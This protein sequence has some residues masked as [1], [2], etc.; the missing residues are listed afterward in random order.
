MTGINTGET[1]CR[2]EKAAYAAMERMEQIGT[3]SDKADTKAAVLASMAA[4]G[5]MCR[6]TGICL[7]NN[8]T[9]ASSLIG[10]Y[11]SI[12]EQASKIGVNCEVVID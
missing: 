11:T 2:R 6:H 8:P 1:N 3:P 10:L 9:K 7:A 4:C 5:E 12:F